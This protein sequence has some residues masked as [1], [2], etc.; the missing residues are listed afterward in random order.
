MYLSLSDSQ[1]HVQPEGV[2]KANIL[3]WDVT[4]FDE[5]LSFRVCYFPC[6]RSV[7]P[8][9]H[10]HLQTCLGGSERACLLL[11]LSLSYSDDINCGLQGQEVCPFER[12]RP[13]YLPDLWEKGD[14]KDAAFKSRR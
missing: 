14:K 10:L 8:K 4:L 9:W 11:C 7:V 2:F 3:Q 1:T 6:L 5:S 13:P 12:I